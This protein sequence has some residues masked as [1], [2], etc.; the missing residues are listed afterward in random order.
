MSEDNAEA[1]DIPETPQ[2]SV[3]EVSRGRDQEFSNKIDALIADAE[4]TR[5]NFMKR[6]RTRG[7]I[8]TTIGLISLVIGSGG[9]GWYLLMEADILRAVASMLAAIAIPA[10]LY[11]WSGGILK[12]YER[13]YKREF[14]PRLANALGGFK[15]HPTRGIS[16]K[17]ISKTG[18]IPRHDIYTAED[19]FMGK[20][21]GVKVLFSEAR[22]TRKANKHEPIFDGIF[23]LLEI[24]TAVI[25]GHTIVTADQNMVRQWRASRW[26]KLQDVSIK[27]GNPDWDR[28]SI[29]SDNPEGAQL[30]IGEKLLKEL[31]E[32]ADV[33]DQSP[34][35]AAFFRGKFVFLMIP[36]QGDMF[37]AS[38]I[39]LPVATKQHAMQ[40]KREIEQILE[41]IDVFE[42]YQPTKGP[43]ET[44]PEEPPKSAPAE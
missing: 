30:I 1:E 7:N 8:V 40:C 4:A 29:F 3:E 37:E 36:Y 28:F 19:C 23:V 5:L 6:H 35:S 41:I 44:P 9:F 38:N 16:G 21:K 31:S 18:L 12:A 24:P 25:E 13:N 32:A 39:H 10:L 43:G 27:T 15:F 2:M 20:Y 33:F 34:M 42:L 22:L 17:I 26:K 14:L 11:G